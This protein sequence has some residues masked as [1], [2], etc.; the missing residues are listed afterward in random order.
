MASLPL[1]KSPGS[2]R[3]VNLYLTREVPEAAASCAKSRYD[4]SLSEL[5]EALLVQ[6]MKTKTGL[7]RRLR[8]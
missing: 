7:L 4:L 8:T 3:S 1:K 6:E 2:K 5:V